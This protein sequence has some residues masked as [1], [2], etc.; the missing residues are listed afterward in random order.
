MKKESK[1]PEIRY[2]KILYTTDLSETGRYAFPYAASLAHRDDAQLTVLHIV[3]AHDFEK[4]LVGYIDKPL[5]DEIKN[6]DLQEARNLLLHRRRQDVNIVDSVEEFCQSALSDHDD[7][8]DAFVTYN[9]AVEMGEPVEVILNKAKKE[10]Y[11]LIVIGKHGHGVLKGGLIGDTAQRV[12]RRSH[13]PVL[14]IKVPD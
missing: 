9:I 2:T 6:R 11:D 13:I 7:I 14:V 1:V 4:H 3:E 12:V 10:D 8:D 5:W